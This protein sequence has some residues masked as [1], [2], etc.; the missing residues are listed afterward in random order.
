[1]IS[2]TNFSKFKSQAKRRGKPVDLT[3]DQF[4]KIKISECY[5]C[6]VEYYLYADFCKKLGFKT[7]YMTVDRMDNKVGY[8]VENSVPCC[9]ICNRI[10]SNFFSA[11]EMKEI[12]EKFV[13]P[14][15]ETVKENV[16]EEYL[17]SVE[18]EDQGSF[19]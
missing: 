18:Y 4:H 19:D 16:W 1:M 10:K 8:T 2:K 9:F 7:P 13:K 17:E 3:F 11:E 15:F 14:K 6:K 5:Y 12:G